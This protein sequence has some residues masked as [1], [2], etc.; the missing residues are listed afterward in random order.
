[1]RR[2]AFLVAA[3]V[4]VAGCGTAGIGGRAPKDAKSITYE[5]K[6]AKADL[7]G[8]AEV[9]YTASDGTTVTKT[10]SMPWES[11]AIS[12]EAGRSYRLVAS[13]PRVDGSSFYCGVHTDSRR[14]AGNSDPSGK[15]SYTF[16]DD[17]GN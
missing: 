17:V 8:Q 7:T 9:T 4:L 12:V 3:L 15:C 16:P 13:A 5:A 2:A 11:E 10:V 1:M 6:Y 14:N